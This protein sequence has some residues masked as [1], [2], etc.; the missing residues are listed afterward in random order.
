MVTIY[1][2]GH[3]NHSLERF[4]GLLER[5]RIELVVDV[6]SRPY[7][8]YVPH[9]DQEILEEHLRSHGI[10]YRF[11]G[12][13][14]G[15]RPEGEA[16]RREDGEVDYERWRG[17]ALFQE[18]IEEV[19]TLGEQFRLTLLCGEEDPNRCHRKLLIGPALRE[20]EVEILHIRGDGSLEKD[21]LLL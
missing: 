7:S 6:R 12:D 13:K 9:F 1:T 19:I 14:L 10:A 16:F 3:S 8:R 5:Y 17:S 15:G 20:K 4:L 21:M 2:V 18:G 11:L